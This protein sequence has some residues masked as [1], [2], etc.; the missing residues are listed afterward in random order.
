MTDE[1]TP[2]VLHGN[3][4]LVRQA[5]RN[6]MQNAVRHNVDGGSIDLSTEPVPGGARLIIANSGQKHSPVIVELLVEPFV[7]G[8]GRTAS[9]GGPRARARPRE[10]R[11]GRASRHT[12]GDRPGFEWASHRVAPAGGYTAGSLRPRSRGHDGS[13]KPL[14]SARPSPWP[15]LMSM[16]ASRFASAIRLA[17]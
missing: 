17:A 8:H 14:V 1:V 10:K 11:G 2:T 15:H 13:Q 5:V 6:L 7:R 12:R 9:R 16:R 4:V 3:G